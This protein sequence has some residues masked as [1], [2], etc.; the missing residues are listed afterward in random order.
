VAVISGERGPLAF[1]ERDAA[2]DG[3]RE[4]VVV[5]LCQ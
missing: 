4:V 5:Q 1:F 3:Q 2:V